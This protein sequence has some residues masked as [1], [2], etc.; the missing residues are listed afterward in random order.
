[1]CPSFSSDSFE[2]AHSQ[3]NATEHIFHLIAGPNHRK[4]ERGEHAL[5]TIT[6]RPEQK[7]LDPSLQQSAIIVSPSLVHFVPLLSQ[8][9]M[10][11]G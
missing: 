4:K 1:M 11:V 2:H 6:G 10:S 7:S 9:N 3:P 5:K 8:K